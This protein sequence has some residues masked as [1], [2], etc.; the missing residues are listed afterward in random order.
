MLGE[1]R[2]EVVRENEKTKGKKNSPEI[3]QKN[4]TK[5]ILRF[6]L[7]EALLILV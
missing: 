5:N 1:R 4:L 2:F 6:S 3:K 7:K